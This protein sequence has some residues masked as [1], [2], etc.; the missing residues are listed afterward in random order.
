MTHDFE[1]D[2]AVAAFALLAK[3]ARI[4]GEDFTS[5]GGDIDAILAGDAARETMLALAVVGGAL[6]HWLGSLNGRTVDGVLDDVAGAVADVV[7]AADG[8]GV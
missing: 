7:A 5:V 6:A 4:E 3:A 1:V 8:G 2:G